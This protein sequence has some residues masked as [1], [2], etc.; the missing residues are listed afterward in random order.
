MSFTILKEELAFKRYLKL[1]HRKV[2][3]PD[4]RIFDWDVVGVNS[5]GPHFCVVFPYN[6]KTKTVRV[7]REYSQG[8]NEMKF[9]LVAG[10][11][12]SK[13]HKDM[14]DVAKNELSEEAG[15]KEGNMIC[16]LDVKSRGIA[17]LKWGLNHFL[18]FLCLDPLNDLDPK[19]RDEEGLISLI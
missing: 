11:F 17:E 5:T 18:P 15:L 1:W 14:L 10:G 9:T 7:L 13:K 19:K 8:P 4:G 16:L 6:T 2:Q 12:D 3:Y